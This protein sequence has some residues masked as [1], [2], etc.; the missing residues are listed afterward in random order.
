MNDEL[1]SPSVRRALVADV[2]CVIL[3]AT[4]GRASHGEVLSPGGL[5]R[6]GTPFVLGL[7]V[8]WVIIV[9]VRIAALRWSAG[10]VLWAS[11]IIVGMVVRHFT[12]QG[13]AVTFIIVAACFLALTLIGWRV[14]ATAIGVARR[15]RRA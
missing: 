1:A 5:L 7:A 13:V 11:T 8:G 6:T 12:G 14:I 9:T 10:A 4:I 2:I 3:F 15:K